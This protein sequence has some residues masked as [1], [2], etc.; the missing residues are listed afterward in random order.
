MSRT[1][2]FLSGVTA[3]VVAGVY[4]AQKYATQVP[5]VEAVVLDLVAKV[6]TAIAAAQAPKKAVVTTSTVEVVEVKEEIVV[7]VKEE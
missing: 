3:G 7:A 2:A 1:F 6:Q 4:V 5:N